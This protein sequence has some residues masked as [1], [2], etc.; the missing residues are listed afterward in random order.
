MAWTISSSSNNLKII[1]FIFF[2][3]VFNRKPYLFTKKFFDTLLP[4]AKMLALVMLFLTLLAHLP[5]IPLLLGET[6]EQV[7]LVITNFIEGFMGDSNVYNVV[8]SLILLLC[9]PFLL[10]RPFMAWLSAVIGRSGSFKNAF[11]HTK[12]RY[13][14]F[15][16]ILAT[17]YLFVCGVQLLDMGLHLNG[18]LL[19][20]VVSP[21]TILVNVVMAKTYEA[22]F[23]N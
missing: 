16:L 2:R 3:F 14:M 9:S 15:L 21:L 13:K 20:I 10:Y 23:L 18:W 17:F 19:N 11:K 7:K 5:Y 8:V 22:L 12:G 1:N 4:A 6:S